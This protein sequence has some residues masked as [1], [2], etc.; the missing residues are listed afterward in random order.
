M[1]N[2]PKHLLRDVRWAFYGGKF[3]SFN[4]FI[5][6]VYEYSSKNKNW[7][8]EQIILSTNTYTIQWIYWDENDEMQEPDKQVSSQN[9][10]LTAGELLYNIHNT[11]V[12]DL[13]EADN[14]FFEGLELYEG[15]LASEIPLYF[16]LQGS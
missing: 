8:H 11:V 14:H 6:A 4:Q 2:Y 9:D 16:L 7:N 3:Q 10:N 5:D 12:T 13:E 1:K 15:E